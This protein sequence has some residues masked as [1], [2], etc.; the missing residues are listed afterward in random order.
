MKISYIHSDNVFIQ[1]SFWK[2]ARNNW[3]KE[4]KTSQKGLIKVW[5]DSKGKKKLFW[6]RFSQENCRQYLNKYPQGLEQL[7]THGNPERDEPSR[8]VEA[9]SLK[10]SK[11]SPNFRT[12]SLYPCFASLFSA[13]FFSSSLLDFALFFLS[14]PVE[15][16]ILNKRTRNILSPTW[17][18]LFT[19]RNQKLYRI[20]SVEFTKL[21]ILIELP[22]W[23][24][25]FV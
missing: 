21:L 8:R 17:T 3:H 22:I 18:L 19:Q 12:T 13:T 24:I 9:K 11:F 4:M 23:Y 5:S 20:S 7:H 25:E 1:F 16:S 14:I 2:F 15:S 10:S 6:K